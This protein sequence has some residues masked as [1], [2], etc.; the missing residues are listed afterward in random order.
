MNKNNNKNELTI[1]EENKKAKRKIREV[2][3][4]C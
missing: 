4:V 1:N 2:A 3:S